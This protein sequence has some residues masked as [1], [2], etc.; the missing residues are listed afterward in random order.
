MSVLRSHDQRR[1]AILNGEIGIRA[2]L[3]QRLHH[4]AVAS[5]RRHVQRRCPISSCFANISTCLK[6]HTHH[7]CVPLLRCYTK[8]CHSMHAGAIDIGLKL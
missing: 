7:G 2:S 8:R 4:I 3:K 6:E 1:G 5:K